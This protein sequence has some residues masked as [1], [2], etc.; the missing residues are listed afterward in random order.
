MSQSQIR[1]MMLVLCVL[2]LCSCAGGDGGQD[3]ETR[4]TGTQEVLTACT[5]PAAAQLEPLVQDAVWVWA[6]RITEDPWTDTT[7]RHQVDM[8]QVLVHA[9][10]L[11]LGLPI[12]YTRTTLSV[13]QPN[14]TFG[15]SRRRRVLT[16]DNARDATEV[17]QLVYDGVTDACDIVVRW[18]PPC[19][20]TFWAR[21]TDGV[22]Q[23]DPVR[24]WYVRP[25]SAE[26][27]PLPR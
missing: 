21:Y 15:E 17:P 3:N 1:I 5:D 8:G 6:E 14:V 16:L 22:I 26:L 11:A 24:A 9:F 4:N 23:V 10:G 20:P 27:S 12:D 13:M 18:E 25:E 2:S 19:C 7:P